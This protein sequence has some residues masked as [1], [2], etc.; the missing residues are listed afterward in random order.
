MVSKASDDFPDPLRPV[1]TVRL[2]RGISTSMFLRLCCRAPRTVIRSS[3]P[4]ILPYSRPRPDFSPAQRDSA[5]TEYRRPDRDLKHDRD[6]RTNDDDLVAQK[7][8]GNRSPDLL[9]RRGLA[10]RPLVSPGTGRAL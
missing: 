2:L 5:S 4:S 7:P 6:Q 3:K 1:M 9:R 10:A 8:A